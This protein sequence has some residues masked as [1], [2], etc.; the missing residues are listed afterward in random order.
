MDFSKTALSMHS[1][2]DLVENVYVLCPT[3][4]KLYHA[5]PPA[6]SLILYKLNRGIRSHVILQ[7]LRVQKH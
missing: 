4:V 3:L 1:D 7:V 2:S 6:C 5:M